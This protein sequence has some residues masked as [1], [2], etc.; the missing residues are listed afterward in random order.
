MD[1]ARGDLILQ[2]PS[3][4]AA[5]RG[6]LHH[7]KTFLLRS[8]VSVLIFQG[9]SCASAGPFAL[10]GAFPNFFG[11]GV[12]STTEYAGGNERIVGALPG[13][14][15]TTAS[16]HLLEWYGPYAQFN[17]GVGSEVQ[18]GPALSLRLGRH[19]V[20][21][22]VVA[23]IHTIATTVEG[24]GFVGYEYVHVGNVPY[25]IRGGLTVTTDAGQVFTGSQ[26]SIN[27]TA[28]LPLSPRIFAGAGLGAS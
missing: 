1:Y 28:W 13:L 17:L 4:G 10:P 9:A 11:V 22:P 26:V 12:G 8:A 16:G 15:Y 6:P 25:R 21:D 19:D 3:N 27:G 2:A 24:G 23:R 18:W 5:K 14:R 7:K 20:D